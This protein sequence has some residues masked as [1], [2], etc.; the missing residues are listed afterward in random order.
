[1]VA[2][3]PGGFGEEGAGAEVGEAEA[4]LEGGGGLVHVGDAG[5]GVK[6]EDAGGVGEEGLGG[7]G[8]FAHAWAR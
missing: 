8:F 2:A 5:L 1:M 6:D 4:G 7:D 3:A